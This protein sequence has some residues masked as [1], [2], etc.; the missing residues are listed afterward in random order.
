MNSDILTAQSATIGLFAAY[1]RNAGIVPL[2][3]IARD[4]DQ[5]AK[6][7]PGAGAAYLQDLA[8]GLSEAEAE[9]NP[10]AGR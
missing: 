5:Q 10:Q 7:V 3:Q 9:I 6:V 1:L 4:L 8:K 2:D